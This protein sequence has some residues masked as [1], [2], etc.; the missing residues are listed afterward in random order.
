MKTQISFLICLGILFTSFQQDVS[1][2]LFE[3]VKVFDFKNVYINKQISH[4]FMIEC[5]SITPASISKIE[6]IDPDKRFSDLKYSFEIKQ[7]DSSRFTTPSEYNKE[8]GFP[9]FKNGDSIKFTI[10]FNPIKSGDFFQFIVLKNNVKDIYFCL[11]GSV[12][13]NEQDI[14]I[15]ACS[16]IVRE[17][18]D[19]TKEIE[20]S[21]PFND[22]S[23]HKYINKS[24]T[25]YYAYI[26]V[27]GYTYNVLN[28]GVFIL[29]DDGT[30]ISKPNEK[31]DVRLSSSNEW[32]YTSMI[33]LSS[34]DI[35]NLKTKKIKKVRLY[36]YD[37][38]LNPELIT[39]LP[40]QMQC[41]LEMK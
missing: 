29:F 5:K 28:E 27:N 11:D 39:N 7:K 40:F 21:T 9:I 38:E 33:K 1:P 18:D 2:V 26:K 15:A 24:I 34:T 32:E 12:I 13:L 16:Q 22:L 10:T 37:S 41:L 36:I 35:A 3:G 19:F 8:S 25:T 4:S 30:K 14:K 23:L 20:L 31:I 6:A 17:I